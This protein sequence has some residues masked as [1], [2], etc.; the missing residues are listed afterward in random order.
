MALAAPGAAQIAG[1]SAEDGRL[2]GHLAYAQAEAADLADAP[3]GFGV[4]QP[5]RVRAVVLPDLARLLDAAGAAG[6]GETLHGISCFRS[7]A[8]QQAVFCRTAATCANAARR[9]GSVGPPGHS[10]HA[11]GYAIDFAVRPS[12][13][14]RDVTDCIAETA[15]GRWLLAHGPRY[16]FEL[17]FPAGNAQGVTYEPWHWRWAGTSQD[18]PGAAEARATFA[19]ARTHFPANPDEAGFALRPASASDGPTAR[20]QALPLN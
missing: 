1:E 15:A 20:P 2:L 5:C 14:C 11:T 6:L 9:A 19:E 3:R 16:G 7:V 12:R 17:S 13:G 10:E 18:E 4:G 8:R